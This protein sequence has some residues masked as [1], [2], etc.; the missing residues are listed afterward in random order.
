M[1]IN[2]CLPINKSTAGDVLGLVDAQNDRFQY[3]EFWLDYL[4]PLESDFVH[5][6]AERLQSRAIF[7]FRRQGVSISSTPLQVRQQL[8]RGIA[9]TGA[10]VDIDIAQQE[11]LNFLAQTKL[12]LPLIASY[13]N[14]I[15]TPQYNELFE[16]LQNMSRCRPAIY[17]LAA[18]CRSRRHALRLLNF[19]L[20]L[21]RQNIRKI[22]LGMGENGI[23]PRLFG[24]LWGNELIYAPLALEDA[25]AP[26]QLTRDQLEAVF[27]NLPAVFTDLPEEE[28]EEDA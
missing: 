13:H 24:T 19:I 5:S 16:I 21:S 2:Y 18:F 4:Q 7:L 9:G 22:V 15:T 10:Y 17:K 28:D 25:S 8:Y 20:D 1:A 12:E 6:L 23:P 27:S 3:F 26:G 11:D 14:F